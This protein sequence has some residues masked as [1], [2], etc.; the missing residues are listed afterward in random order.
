MFNDKLKVRG[1]V[2]IQMRR[3]SGLVED[4]YFKNLVVDLGKGFIASRMVGNTPNV[5]SHMAVG[6]NNT[7]PAGSQTTLLAEAARVALDSA[8]SAGPVVT[9]TATFGPGVGT[10]ALVEAGLFNA[11]SLGLM[12]SRVVFPVV[13]KGAGDT[14]AVTWTITVT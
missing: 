9:Y 14:M 6:T 8:G 13:N 7:A 11:A 1:D 4:F 3:A 2:H 5:M 10:G 12:E